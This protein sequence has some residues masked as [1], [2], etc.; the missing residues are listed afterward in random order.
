MAIQ[1]SG[2]PAGPLGT[3]ATVL[4]GEAAP[5]IGDLDHISHSTMAPYGIMPL[6]SEQTRPYW[7][8]AKDGKL[9][10]QRCQSCGYYN[11]PPN[12]M[13]VNCKDR[14]AELKWEAVSGNGTLYTH[15]ICYDTSISGFEEKVP[16]AVILVELDEQPG[17]ILMS[18]IL[19]HQYDV[20]GKGLEMGLPLEVIFDKADDDTYV[21]QFQPR[22]N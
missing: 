8:G 10:I 11:H 17:L 3:H 18:N 16:Y 5:L 19:N 21:P 6:A 14:D 13:C 20:F 15:Y 1:D 4:G 22:K 9:T 12:Y 2:P 7:D